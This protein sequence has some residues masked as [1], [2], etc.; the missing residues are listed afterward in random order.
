MSWRVCRLTGF[1][2][3]ARVISIVMVVVWN[4]KEKRAAAVLEVRQM[5]QQYTPYGAQSAQQPATY[6]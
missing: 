2:R 1:D 4:R 3:F 5:P 6:A